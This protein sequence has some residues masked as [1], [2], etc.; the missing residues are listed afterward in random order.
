MS[1][2]SGLARPF[3]C[4]ST[5]Q[6]LQDAWRSFAWDM[7]LGKSIASAQQVGP[8]LSLQEDSHKIH[9]DLA[10]SDH[11][12]AFVLYYLLMWQYQQPSQLLKNFPLW[13]FPFHGWHPGLF[14][15]LLK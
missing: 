12:C 7:G 3:L 1:H 11:F 8:Y 9:L 14:H 6:G 13:S 5:C 15:C 10:A 2:V 4:Y